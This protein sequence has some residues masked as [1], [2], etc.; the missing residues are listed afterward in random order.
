MKQDDTETLSLEEA[1]EM[2]EKIKDG[3]L[4]VVT[5]TGGHSATRLSGLPDGRETDSNCDTNDTQCDGQNEPESVE[6]KGDNNTISDNITDNAM[7]KFG[8]ST[9]NLMQTCID[10]FQNFFHT[11]VSNKLVQDS[12]LVKKCVDSLILKSESFGSPFNVNDDT[13]FSE[14]EDSTENE[15][16]ET[17]NRSLDKLKISLG[18]VDDKCLETFTSACQLMVEFASFPMYSSDSRG[19]F[20]CG[21]QAQGEPLSFINFLI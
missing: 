1:L 19:Q 2:N 14:S 16:T 20:A 12:E 17:G 4:D 21:Q 13:V 6:S 15:Q 11:L 9:K 7:S 8:G 3:R 10:C 18:Y 5:E